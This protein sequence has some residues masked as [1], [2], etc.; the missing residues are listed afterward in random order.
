MHAVYSTIKPQNYMYYKYI[1][2]LQLLPI[3]KEWLPPEAPPPEQKS[4]N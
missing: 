1:I 2:L 4:P 3:L